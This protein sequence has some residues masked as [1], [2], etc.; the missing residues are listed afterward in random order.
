MMTRGKTREIE[1]PKV[2]K[3]ADSL[4]IFKEIGK[5][6]RL[7]CLEFTF[8]LITIIYQVIL[9]IDLILI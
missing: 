1:Y 6:N 3:D 2:F 4:Q 8:I 7:Y 5:M 9:F